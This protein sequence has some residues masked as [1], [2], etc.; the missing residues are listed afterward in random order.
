MKCIYVAFLFVYKRFYAVRDTFQ[1]CSGAFDNVHGRTLEGTLVTV[2]DAGL[3][4][5]ENGSLLA[6]NG[7]LFAQAGSLF[8]QNGSL[9]AQN[10]S[11]TRHDPA[12]IKPWERLYLKVQ[13][14]SSFSI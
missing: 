2:T 7:S 12:L 14:L 8:A 3:H 10:G 1:T 6:Q 11:S 5:V 13:F 4:V 9:F